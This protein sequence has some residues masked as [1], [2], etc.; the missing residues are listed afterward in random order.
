MM[1]HAENVRETYRLQGEQRA[2]TELL[3]KLTNKPS[4]TTDYIIY[5]L[6]QRSEQNGH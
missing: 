5:Y 6:R 1:D 3:E 4:V 2:L